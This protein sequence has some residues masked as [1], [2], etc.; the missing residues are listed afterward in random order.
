MNDSVQN[1]FSSEVQ[2]G[3]RVKIS[4]KRKYEIHFREFDGG[5]HDI[6]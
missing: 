6:L 1:Q 5:F 4:T 3:F 2:K